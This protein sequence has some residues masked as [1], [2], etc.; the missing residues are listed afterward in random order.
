MQNIA[1]VVQQS[2]EVLQLLDTCRPYLRRTQ[3][4]LE[5]CQKSAESLRRCCE[6][7]NEIQENKFEINIAF[8]STKP[9]VGKSYIINS[10]TTNIDG[11]PAKS[12]SAMEGEGVT[13]IPTRYRYGRKKQYIRHYLN[14]EQLDERISLYPEYH[15]RSD[16]D[17]SFQQ[18]FSNGPVRKDITAELSNTEDFFTQV[19]SVQ[20]NTSFTELFYILYDEIIYPFRLIE[21]AALKYSLLDLPGYRDGKFDFRFCQLYA[22]LRYCNIHSIAGISNG[23]AGRGRP[24]LSDLQLLV[25]LRCFESNSNSNMPPPNYM[26]LLNSNM[27]S[28]EGY[29][30]Q[31]LDSLV[32]EAF[33][34]AF[35]LVEQQNEIRNSQS[36]YDEIT[37]RANRSLAGLENRYSLYQRIVNHNTVH[38]FYKANHTTLD[39][40]QKWNDFAIGKLKKLLAESQEQILCHQALMILAELSVPLDNRLKAANMSERRLRQVMEQFNEIITLQRS[41]IAEKLDEIIELSID[42][43]ES[44]TGDDTAV[45]IRLYDSLSFFMV[46]IVEELAKC[47][48]SEG[49]RPTVP[50]HAEFVKQHYLSRHCKAY[51]RDSMLLGK[52]VVV[53]APTSAHYILQTIIQLTDYVEREYRVWYDDRIRQNGSSKFLQMRCQNVRT[54]CEQLLN[55]FISR[56]QDLHPF[57]INTEVDDTAQQLAK[58]VEELQQCFWSRLRIK[59]ALPLTGPKDENININTRPLPTPK[60]YHG[61]FSIPDGHRYESLQDCA[62]FVR[63]FNHNKFITLQ[64]RE[65]EPIPVIREDNEVWFRTLP[66]DIQRNTI[67]MICGKKHRE[68]RIVGI[69]FLENTS[70]DNILKPFQEIPKDSQELLRNI[71]PVFIPTY[72]RNATLTGSSQTIEEEIPHIEYLEALRCL[73]TSKDGIHRI[74]FVV[75]EDDKDHKRLQKY[76]RKYGTIPNVYFIVIEHDLFNLNTVRNMGIGRKRTFIQLAAEY[77]KFPF[78]AVI[79]DDIGRCEEFSPIHHQSIHDEYT[80]FRSLSFLRK[81]L[82]NEMFSIDTEE[83][84]KFKRLLS[85]EVTKFAL[86]ARVDIA[87]IEPKLD[88]ISETIVEYAERMEADTERRPIVAWEMMYYLSSDPD[89]ASLARGQPTGKTLASVLKQ[90][91]NLFKYCDHIGTAALVKRSGTAYASMFRRLQNFQKTTHFISSMIYQFVMYYSDAV[92]GLYH[93]DPDV[94]F[95]EDSLSHQ[96][97]TQLMKDSKGPDDANGQILMKLGYKHEDKYHHRQLLLHGVTGFQVYWY[98][99]QDN[100]EESLVNGNANSF[101]AIRGQTEA[102]QSGDSGRSPNEATAGSLKRPRNDSSGESQSPKPV[103]DN[104]I[105]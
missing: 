8:F 66:Q 69:S 72:P 9:G 29:N 17:I 96:D 97:R 52:S 82:L 68:E 13:N 60:R 30:E 94:F 101:S 18:H 16:F 41:R 67:V 3:S 54:K 25:A 49:V 35:G 99:I 85:A 26:H 79:D 81:L 40:I 65:R 6:I 87:M 74:V 4:R 90:K 19:K 91:F 24:E 15:S 98:S 95:N 103:R 22:C 76:H 100:E 34:E 93:V 37:V 89:V 105:L 53:A 31:T 73:D 14:K 55:D 64:R 104:R 43:Y 36:E 63:T 39:H 80:W 1:D 62:R 7:L 102:L 56:M 5:Y 83:L 86:N 47:I 20:E 48:N 84:R 44:E 2:K 51:L 71:P 77:F 21:T 88:K 42:E 12:S 50:L 11:V 38:V 70:W 57:N 46:E 58:Q 78:F 32:N 33:L 92:K 28:E 45:L 27:I 59:N 75:F 23:I 10:L 61:V